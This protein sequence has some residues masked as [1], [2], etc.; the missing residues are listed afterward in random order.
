MN[1]IVRIK[2]VNSRLLVR[3]FV[4]RNGGLADYLCANR[5]VGKVYDFGGME[6]VRR[7]KRGGIND[8]N[9]GALR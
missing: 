7:S 2:R 1:I 5:R 8:C 3:D 4:E 6:V 9:K